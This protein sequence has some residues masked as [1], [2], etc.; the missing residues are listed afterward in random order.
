[1]VDAISV[2]LRYGREIE[3]RLLVPD[4]LAP[5]ADKLLAP[6]RDQAIDDVKGLL[7]CV[8]RTE[9]LG[10]TVAIYPDAEEY[11]QQKLLQQRLAAAVADIRRNPGDHP[12]RGEL[13]N[14]DLRPYQLDGIALAAGAGRA[15][16]ADDMGLG[17]TIQ[18]IGVAQL[19][20]RHVPISKV[21]KSPFALVLTGTP[22]ENRL[23]EL[24]SVARPKG[25]PEQGL[26][27][28]PSLKG[29]GSLVLSRE[30]TYKLMLLGRCRAAALDF[31]HG[32]KTAI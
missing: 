8:D 13:L 32:G 30:S 1:V 20:A 29:L 2:Y 31:P 7:G 27:T 19:L 3:V 26:N 6:F 5:A 22:L 9:R 14:V 12:L 28:I 4:N 25:S 21:L 11:I 24:F 10:F 18:G 16:L 17:K 15:I 23:D